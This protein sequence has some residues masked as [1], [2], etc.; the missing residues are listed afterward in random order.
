[1]LWLNFQAPALS[2]FDKGGHIDFDDI[3]ME[4]NYDP[5]RSYCRSKLANILFT[6][7]LAR[8][9]LG[10]LCLACSTVLFD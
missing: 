1:M 2:W 10:M 7:E 6:K 8:R 3:M 4:K 9:L 5:T